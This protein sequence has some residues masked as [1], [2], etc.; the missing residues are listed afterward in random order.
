MLIH[1]RAIYDKLLSAFL[2]SCNIWHDGLTLIGQ[3]AGPYAESMFTKGELRRLA[4]P[5]TVPPLIICASGRGQHRSMIDFTKGSVELLRADD[6][7]IL[8]RVRQAGDRRLLALIPRHA[9][10]PSLRKLENEY[11]L[12]A[13]LDP[14]WAVIPIQLIPNRD[15]M[16]LVLED[17]GGTPV[18]EF[19]GSPLEFG[20]RLRLAVGLAEVVA[21][22]HRYG[23]LHRDIK[24]GN[25]LVAEGGAVWL[26]G[27]GIAIHQAQRQ[28]PTGVATGSLPYMA[29]EQT[30]R[31]DRP[32]DCRSDLY[33]LGVTF[34]E[35]F[36]GSLPFFA[37]EPE[38]WIHCHLARAPPLAVERAPHLPVQISAIVLKLMSKEPADRYQS[39]E[40]LSADL[41][42]CL[43][44]WTAQRRVHRF[45]LGR[46]DAATALRIPRIL[47]GRK[48]ESEAL[49]AALA[50]VV[51]TGQ[52]AV[53]LI[54][55]PSGVGKSSLIGEFQSALAPGAA[56]M[57]SGKFDAQSRNVPY[58]AL[59]QAFGSLLRKILTCDDDSVA[60]WRRVLAEAIGPN[61]PL[62]AEVIPELDLLLGP[63]PVLPELSPHDRRN[64]LRT[65]FRRLAGAFARPGRPLILFVDDL[66]WLDAATLDV[67]GD[68]VSRPHGSNLMLLGAYRTDEV[69]PVRLLT[70][71]LDMIRAAGIPVMELVL[72]PLKP[73]DLAALIAETLDRTRAQAR[74]L[75]KLVHAK[76]GGNPFF[77][78]QFLRMLNDEGVLAYDPRTGSWRWDVSRV[79]AKGSADSV[80]DLMA[81]KLNLL[82]EGTRQTLQILASFGSA[83]ELEDLVVASGRSAEAVM[84]SLRPALLAGLIAR[85]DGSYVFV[86]D[87]VQEAA[88]DLQSAQDK[89][90][91]H[92]RIGL[93]LV[94]CR[95]PD[96]AGEK[97]YIVANQLNRGLA[98]VTSEAEREL[99]IGVNLSAGRRARDAAAY[100]AAIVY[101]DAAHHLLEER[102]HPRH[103]ATAFAIAFQRAECEF[104]VG[105]LDAAEMQ[106]QVLSQTCPNLQA[107]AEVTKLRANLYTIRGQLARGVDVCLEFLRQVGID[108]RPHPT[109]REVDEEGLRLRRF[110]EQLSDDWI[111]SLP[112]MTDP[113]CR[114]TMAVFGDLIPPAGLTDHNLSH[115]VLLA[116]TRLTLEHGVCSE[117]CYPLVCVFDVLDSRY[118][119]T[120]LGIRL[121]QFGVSLADQQ[122]QLQLSGRTLMVFGHLVTPWIQPIRDGRPPMQ[123]ALAIAMATG[124]LAFAAYTYR[125]LV[126]A[127]LF[128]G[129]PLQEVCLDAE[130][131]AAFTGESGF[132]L[133][134]EALAVQ[135]NM[136][137]TLMGSDG[138]NHFERLSSTD[139]HPSEATRPIIAFFHYAAQIQIDVLAG[140]HGAALVL[141]ERAE[142]LSWIARAYPELVEYRFYAALAH[143]A[144]HDAASPERRD[145]HIN[146]VRRHQSELTT[147]CAHVRANFADRLT[148]L[149]AEVARIEGRELD[150]ERLYEES[151]QL[152]REAGFVQIEAIAAEH[153]ARFH[154]A[155][156]LRTVMLS[157][158]A[159]ARHCYLRWG[160]GAKV[161]QLDRSGPHL[162]ASE[163]T[164]ALSA[165]PDTP[166]HQLDVS[167]LF[168]ASR[169]LSG[170]VVLDALIRTLMRVVIEHTAAERGILFL[171][172]SDGPQA[173]AEAR[174]GSQGIEV[175]VWEAGRHDLEFS[176]PAL[177]YVVHT[178]AAFDLSD[179]ADSSLL[180]THPFL[181]KDS[182][183]SLRCLPIVAQAKLVG[184][185]YLENHV[186]IGAFTPHQAAVLDILA[187]QAAISFENAR[188]YADLR[189]SE[190]FLSHGEM[191]NHSGSWSWDT[192]TGRILW[193]HEHYRIFGEDPEGVAEP[194][195][196]RVIRMVHPED[197]AELRR[198]VRS[199]IDKRTAFSCEYR[200]VRADGVRHLRAV[201][202]PETDRFGSLRGYA[203]T[204][205]DITD[206][207]RAQET[208]Q[209]AQSDLAR[210]SR[211]AVIGELSSLI[212]HEVRQPLT[213]IA[214][215]AGACRSW[216][217]PDRPDISQ[218]AAAAGCIVEDAHRA[219][220]VIESIRQ[221]TKKSTPA[222]EAVNLN[223]VVRETVNLLGSEIHRQRVVLKVDFAD[224]LPSVLGDRVQ[225]QQVVMNLM[226]NGI[227]AMAAIPDRLRRL[228]VNTETTSAGT[229]LVGVE[230]VG[231]G[232]PADRVEHLFEAFFSTKPN[233]L[234]VGLA[235]CRSI[236]ESHGG[237]LWAA[238]NHPRGSVFRFRLP[239]LARRE[240]VCGPGKE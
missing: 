171:M 215:Q 28:G 88:Y 52:T 159:N 59:T 15:N 162:P 77:A 69:G 96:K 39:A 61:G 92:L 126:S 156:G 23:L 228:S 47:Y 176:Q 219:S 160:A 124:D 143:A 80:A 74:P 177:N 128:C 108:W 227:E 87:R 21:K 85:R 226:I 166:L 197:R 199:S 102:S 240:Q 123:R 10:I 180:S 4:T 37:S 145:F 1:I 148:L 206:H 18:S 75:A 141:A 168:K 51:A 164:H 211:L 155:R 34:Y 118:S 98:A 186:A 204:T 31:M 111:H 116:A 121:V 35:M 192:Q 120:E 139:P 53:A 130:Q 137:L 9:T 191:L 190:A 24:P 173:V 27:F 209:A 238:P 210:A 84:S 200:V 189:R 44:D 99:M 194:T 81:A 68:L 235:I 217:R 73:S 234:G 150:A 236:I 42:K 203:G 184:V 114:A 151:I 109:H 89:P 2:T 224:D 86:H 187:A 30:G 146:G 33:A 142:G 140:R 93:A 133:P 221:M 60:D 129:D 63:Q 70:S 17:P 26:T 138:E 64:R 158:L 153:A 231:T 41:Q 225:L 48:A 113:D 45:A 101:L 195:I 76:T 6:A 105:H 201:G 5:G 218:A 7:F 11:G 104:L 239:I 229:V 58:A 29:P 136:A 38:E 125:G 94:G 185:L 175:A 144:M 135:W 131:A 72:Q 12:A 182:Q 90:G 71:Q 220:S 183:I 97:L 205:V 56:L 134:A 188:L 147:R 8:Y 122:P 22:L 174:L 115:I 49:K 165:A 95:R 43:A 107:S 40:G 54:S 152:A 82:P 106:L 32:I 119:D 91:L 36:T 57:G 62:V 214:A 112:P 179:P 181:H 127:R 216:L 149:A 196:L 110:A 55:G 157:Y 103:G 167:A 46:S 213:A 161:R 132:D 25:I 202:R 230:D 172:G 154:E 78:V 207:K 222:Q 198:M 208:L 19:L 67:V 237:A 83:A 16:M 169:A 3:V 193:S 66:Q 13:S 65:A 100:H 14:A 79:R 232:L 223:D 178:R 117:S 20:E 170:E 233:G 50:R 212:A 163:P